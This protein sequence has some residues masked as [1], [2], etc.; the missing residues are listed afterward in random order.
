MEKTVIK[1][2]KQWAQEY[3]DAG[4]ALCAIK[5]GLKSPKG[6]DW[7][8]HPKNPDDFLPGE[9]IGL[10]HSLSNTCVLDLDNL[11]KALPYF[12]SHG[13]DITALL[14]ASDAVRIASGRENRAKLLYKLPNTVKSLLTRK[15]D[16]GIEFRC[17]PR[18]GFAVQDVLPPSIHPDTKNAYAWAGKGNINNI[19]ELPQEILSL[20]LTLGSIDTI[21]SSISSSIS[22][23]IKSDLDIFVPLDAI[24]WKYIQSAL[25]FISSDDHDTWYQV[26]MALHPHEGGFDLWQEW[27]ST[28]D[29]YSFEA[30]EDRWYHLEATDITYKTIFSL[31]QKAGWVNPTKGVS[32]TELSIQ[33]AQAEFI[34]TLNPE[35]DENNCTFGRIV[36]LGENRLP[37]EPPK[38]FVDKWLPQGE[39]T[40]LSGHGGGGKSFVA[41]SLAVHIAL[42]IDFGDL[43]VTQAV[44][45]F[46][47]AEDREAT[48]NRRLDPICKHLKHSDGSQVKVAHL[49]GKLF[50]CDTTKEVKRSLYAKEKT[51]ALAQ[52]A[53]HVKAVGASVIFVDNASNA[54]TGNEIDRNEVTDFLQSLQLYVGGDSG[55]IVLLAHI[56]KGAATGVSTEDYSGSTAWHNG[57]RSRLSLVPGKVIVNKPKSFTVEQ[58][59]AT[60]SEVAN[61]LLMVWDSGAFTPVR[62]VEAAMTTL[63]NK[64]QIFASLKTLILEAMYGAASNKLRVF[65]SES[66]PK[67]PHKF[68]ADYADFPKDT[69]PKDFYDAIRELLE[70]GS[71]VALEIRIDYKNKIVYELAKEVE[72]DLW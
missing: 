57:V 72:N 49:E 52:F 1:T 58:R 8:N 2:T 20:W 47:S 30:C 71:I 25:K 6:K 29:K 70:E 9:G 65:A 33:Q 35:T 45:Y 23:S 62:S 19:P 14:N 61:P 54:F 5:P 42:G 24:T 22:S 17:A 67:M 64:H 28:S 3:I 21:K 39:V 16:N 63:D 18:T 11:D 27:S 69:N 36:E 59:K 68:L 41:L 66:G 44:V 10:I 37:V 4:F 38:Y 46:L 51:K 40:L 15:L 12:A 53:N 13:I 31:A 56:S 32:K 26:G 34:E 55:S 60:H 48:L 43:T 7:G 50:I